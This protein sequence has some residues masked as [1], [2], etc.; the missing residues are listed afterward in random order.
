M[1]RVRDVPENQGLNLDRYMYRLVFTKLGR[2]KFISHLD[3]MR[4]MQRAFKRAKLPIWYTQGFN[5]RSYIMFSLAL[6]L[7]MESEIE[8]MDFALLE[9]ISFDD[10]KESLNAVL[11]LGMKIVSVSKPVFETIDIEKADYKL[12]ITTN[13]DVFETKDLFEEFLKLDEINIEKKVKARRTRKAGTKLVNVKE[14]IEPLNIYVKD[15][16]LAI[17]L[18]LATSS[19]NRFNLNANAVLDSFCLLNDIKIT[20]Y[21]AKRTRIIC[22][23]GENFS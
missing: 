15:D 2:T 23:N 17:E 16:C 10:V 22:E 13:K 20:N 12:E 19:G 3:L 21:S 14:Y 7:G 9:E 8:T 5:P 1:A 4:T 6:P 11:P 18:R